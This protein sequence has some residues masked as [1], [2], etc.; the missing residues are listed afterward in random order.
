LPDNLV[1]N[2]RQISQFPAR[3]PVAGSDLVLLQAG[4]LGG[5]YYAATA[6]ALAT[7]IGLDPTAPFV[8]G[9]TAP[10]DAG[11]AQIMTPN[12]TLGPGPLLF[13]LYA[14]NTNGYS[15]LASGPGATLSM[16]DANGDLLFG[17]A[18]SGTA[19]AAITGLTQPL[20]LTPAGHLTLTDTLTVA[21]DPTAALEVATMGWVEA[22]TV[23]SFNGRTGAVT[24]T[25]AD[26]NAAT[27]VVGVV[28]TVPTAPQTATNGEVANAAFVVGLINSSRATSVISFNSRYGAV[29]LGI[30]DI[31]D[32]GGAPLTSPAFIGNP[33]AP[34]PNP[35]TSNTQIA[36]TA[37]VLENAGVTSF[38]TRAGAVTLTAADITAAG[39][40]LL[41]SPN[42]T[43]LPTAPTAIP[44]TSTGQLATTAFVQAA[45]AAATTGVSSFNTRTGAVVLSQ[46]DIVNASGWASPSFTG[47]PLAPTAATATN[48]TQIAT[49]AFVHAALLAGA[50]GVTTFNTRAGA[51]VLT[52]ADV[53]SVNG[54]LLASPA[55]TGVPTANTA[56]PGTNTTQL[57]TTAFV[58]AAL[59]AI[60]TGVTSFNGR[61]GPVVLQGNDVSAAGGAL[62]ASPTFTGVPQAPTA[63]TGD[64]SSQ[65]ATTAFVTE[66]IS[67]GVS[68]VST[69]NGRAGAV[70]MTTADIT[71][72][73]GAPL[74]SPALTGVPLAPTAGPGTNTTQLATTAFVAAAIAA[75]A[76]TSFNTR[77]GAVTLAAADLTAAGGALLA[78]PVFTGVPTAPTASPG[79]A[80]TQLATT[81][82]VMAAPLGLRT[83][84][85]LTAVGAVTYTTPANCKAINVRVVG[86]GGGGA[87]GGTGAGFG[88]DGRL[89][90]FGASLTAAGG[91]GQVAASVGGV[92]G[93]ATGGDDNLSGGHGGNGLFSGTSSF[94]GGSGGIGGI[95]IRGGAGMNG[96]SGSSPT[97]AQP[98]SGGGGGGGLSNVASQYGGGGGGAGGYLEKLIVGPA[99]S[100]ACE[101]GY[102][103][104]GGVIGTGQQAGA[105]G[106]SG[107]IIVDE[108]Y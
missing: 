14:N 41:A 72:A 103:G 61:T 79:I 10:A 54:A 38:N 82:Y 90:N 78:S 91:G 6:S 86:G 75:G 35:G 98:N 29:T 20:I 34:T 27:A 13:N 17:V 60:S 18:T 8:W 49:T 71:A 53:S 11:P 88:G 50:P 1:V 76:V 44:G 22:H 46:A 55:F 36:T 48:N 26:F 83:R 39:G 84:T 58:A 93:S 7:T 99:A 52:A 43:G 15:Y 100:Y 67:A 102:G 24:F 3:S 89:S 28:P 74:A 4:G 32:A 101:V 96:T 94:G 56:V 45:V 104:A 59:A 31:T 62:V 25:V 65:L 66:A 95:S 68:G 97:A 30:N 73:G 42:L 107:I 33:T 57:A 64:S 70:T 5:P 77:I 23:D 51:V 63:N 80:N 21:R 106:G 16:D 12:L 9:M 40:A 92:G 37:Y 2:V 47:V 87:G 105:A 85:V 108:Y 81:A 69:W 19:G